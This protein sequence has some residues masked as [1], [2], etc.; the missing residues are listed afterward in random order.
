MIALYPSLFSAHSNDLKNIIKTID[1]YVDGYHLDVMDGEFV[2]NKAFSAEII[3]DL[4]KQTKKLFF[5]HL[6]VSK[7]EKY[8][9]KLKL[10]SKDVISFHIEIKFNIREIIKY[11]HAKDLFV[12]I[13]VNPQTELTKIINHAREIDHLLLM[14]VNPGQSGQKF[15][16]ST[17]DRIDVLKSLM[18]LN[19]FDFKIG[20]D[21]GVNLLNLDKIL[22]KN[23]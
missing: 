19:Q 18:S 2:N 16:E 1:P 21:G 12:S 17:F 4:R 10:N 5:V 7:P 8:I 9:E 6:M 15:L 13:A 23:I 3:N 22:S 11:I 14:S 20:L